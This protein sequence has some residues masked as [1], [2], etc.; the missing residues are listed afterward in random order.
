M[1]FSRIPSKCPCFS[2]TGD[3]KIWAQWV[4]VLLKSQQLVRFLNLDSKKKRMNSFKV[5]S[6]LHVGTMADSC[7]T[8]HIPVLGNPRKLMLR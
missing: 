7:P 1:V 3:L 2:C 8:T 6:A 4:Q 5:P